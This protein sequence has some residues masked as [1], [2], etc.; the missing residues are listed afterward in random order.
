MPIMDRSLEHIL[1][2]NKKRKGITFALILSFFRHFCQFAGTALNEIIAGRGVRKQA[3]RTIL[4]TI[5]K[6]LII[7]TAILAKDIKGTVAEQTIKILRMLCAVAG[8]ICTFFV[9]EKGIAVFHRDTPNRKIII[10]YTFL[11]Y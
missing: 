5:I 7:A 10:S 2:N 3:G 9:L 1:Q 8:E 11:N 4:N 6:I